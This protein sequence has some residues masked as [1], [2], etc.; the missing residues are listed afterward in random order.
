M[1]VPEFDPSFL[2]ER[3]ELIRQFSNEIGPTVQYPNVI[4]AVTDYTNHDRAQ[5]AAKWRSRFE[6][7]STTRY[8]YDELWTNLLFA[9]VKL[10]VV[11][12]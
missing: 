11:V 9:E 4:H 10:H 12:I 2:P 5:E 6:G 1:N 3:R 7:P 8:V